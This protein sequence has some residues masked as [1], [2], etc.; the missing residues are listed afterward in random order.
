[1]ILTAAGLR[2]SELRDLVAEHPER[3]PELTA[4][5]EEWAEDAGVAAWPWVVRPFWRQVTA[6]AWSFWQPRR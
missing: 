1:M 4:L 6:P 2:F 5:Y 3:V